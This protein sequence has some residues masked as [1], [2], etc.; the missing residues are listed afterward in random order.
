MTQT[1]PEP[2]ADGGTT[3]RPAL[4]ATAAQTTAE[5]PW[6]LRQLSVKVGEYVARMAPLWVEGEIV[7]LNRRPGAGMSFMTLR[8]IDVDMSFSVPVREHVLRTLPVEPVP[9]ARVVIHAKPTFW[10]KR[11][12]LQLEADDI[13]P[14]GLGELLARLEQLKG[15]LAAEGL[16]AA[17]RKQPLVGLICGRESAAERDV[18]VNA[19][20]RWPAVQFEIRE[21]AVQGVKAVREVSAALRELDEREEVD[22]IIISRGGGSLEDLLPFSD[23][24]LTRLVAAAKTPIVSAIGHEVDTPLIDLAADVRASTPTDAAKRV[25]PDI[26]A[27][28]EQLD[29]GR[30]RLRAGIRA[31]IEREQSALDAL[32]SRPVLENPATILAG[33]A[34]EIRSRISLAR[35]LI[36]SRL[37]RAADEIDHLGRQVRSLSPLAT[38]ERGYA[39][40]Q[41][42]D[43]TIIRAPEESAAGQALSVRVAGGRFGVER[44]RT[45]PYTPANQT[46][47]SDQTTPSEEPR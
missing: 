37:D 21:V 4:A 15:V 10:T 11:G 17:S 31:R 36:G 33:R 43:G 9:G 5:N 22:V 7:Q 28:V 30:T 13:R 29:L 8:D 32:R 12:S 44:T 19:Q 3:A 24:Q 14:V 47:P 38:L 6:P 27:E 23:E 40:V 20:R 16:F 45:H 41:D 26:Q 1:S 42:A 39:V 35:T 25:V 18:V 34:D 46:P 2:D